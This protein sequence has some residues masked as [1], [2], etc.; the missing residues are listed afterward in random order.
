MRKFQIGD[1]VMVRYWDDMKAEF[2]LNAW[3]S[4]SVPYS[5]TKGMAPLCGKIAKIKSIDGD[6][7]S[8]TEW[9]DVHS[10]TGFSFS[11][12]MFILVEAKRVKKMTIAEIEK[13]LGYEIEIV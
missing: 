9:E 3:D 8:L 1:R 10:D 12:G 11:R 2:G 13:A 5:F 4:I 6:E 7:L